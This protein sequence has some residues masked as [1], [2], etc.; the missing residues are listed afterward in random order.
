MRISTS[1]LPSGFRTRLPG[2]G[3]REAEGAAA[4]ACGRGERL[5]RRQ[6]QQ[7]GDNLP[8]PARR[9][10]GDRGP[11]RQ[12]ARRRRR[13][14]HARRSRPRTRSR[15]RPAVHRPP[16]PPHR[17]R[18]H[19]KANLARLDAQVHIAPRGPRGGGCARAGRTPPIAVIPS[20][21]VAKG[22]SAARARHPMHTAAAPFLPGR[23]PSGEEEG[24][25]RGSGTV[26]TARQRRHTS[27]EIRVTPFR[28]ARDSA[29]NDTRQLAH[30]AMT[31]SHA[32]A[33]TNQRARRD[34]CAGVVP[35]AVA[36][37]ADQPFDLRAPRR[38]AG[39]PSAPRDRR[40]PWHRP[41]R[42]AGAD[43]SYDENDA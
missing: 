35:V 19:R 11:E 23:G 5:P 14:G 21:G 33:V 9:T 40:D 24:Y 39:C 16:P 6:G 18:C 26:H 2:T 10:G 31:S 34:R 30:M 20:A 17:R 8:A 3:C 12:R 13:D 36:R 1:T 37:V 38:R 41:D 29:S 22:P 4:S 32:Y 28:K 7:R 27:R 43:R 25:R 15:H 42:S